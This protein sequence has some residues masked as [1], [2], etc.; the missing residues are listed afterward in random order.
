ME[1]L[2]TWLK[3]LYVSVNRFNPP[4]LCQLRVSCVLVLEASAIRQTRCGA[5]RPGSYSSVVQVAK[6]IGRDLTWLRV[7]SAPCQAR[8]EHD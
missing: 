7:A 6:A 2:I 1:H 4:K 8:I 3:L 5:A